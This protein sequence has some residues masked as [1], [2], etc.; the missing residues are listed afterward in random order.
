MATA[1]A[2]DDTSAVI[3]GI[4]DELIGRQQQYPLLEAAFQTAY[5]GCF[6]KCWDRH[7]SKG[8]YSPIGRPGVVYLDFPSLQDLAKQANCDPKWWHLGSDRPPIWTERCPGAKKLCE[9]FDPRFQMVVEIRCQIDDHL[10][11]EGCT[12]LTNQQARLRVDQ[13]DTYSVEQYKAS[14]MAA[15]KSIRRLHLA[16]ITLEDPHQT[17]RTCQEC[18]G[19]EI[20]KCEWVCCNLCRTANYCTESC[21]MANWKKHDCYSFMMLQEEAQQFIKEQRPALVRSLIEE[22]ESRNILPREAAEALA[23]EAEAWQQGTMERYFQHPTKNIAYQDSEICGA[24]TSCRRN[25]DS[26]GVVPERCS[27]CLREC[28]GECGEEF[29]RDIFVCFK[30]ANDDAINIGSLPFLRQ[31]TAKKCELEVKEYWEFDDTLFHFRANMHPYAKAYLHNGGH[32]AGYGP[33]QEDNSDEDADVD[34]GDAEEG[35]GNHN[36]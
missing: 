3:A 20:P 7:Y 13:T 35:A 15:E 9:L 33:D 34:A 30:C 16:D 6:E 10:V 19:Q 1:A 27:W 26:S 5:E 25:H 24:G 17:F 2:D 23:L 12:M 36:P 8:F 28:H 31:L 4:L 29:G 18:G 14:K 21:R 22:C 32:P 11:V